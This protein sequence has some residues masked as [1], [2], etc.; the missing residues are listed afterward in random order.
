MQESAEALATLHLSAS[1]IN[2]MNFLCGQKYRVN[3]ASKN[4]TRSL[5]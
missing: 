3:T 1:H 5:I 2:V 4:S